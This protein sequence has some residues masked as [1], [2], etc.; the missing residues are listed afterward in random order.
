MLNGNIMISVSMIVKNEEE[1]LE[2]CLESVKDL[3]E[4][5]ILDTG[6]TDKTCKIARKYTDRVYENEYKWNDDF[7]EARNLSKSKCTK[8]WI[9]TIDADER[10]EIGGIEKIRKALNANPKNSVDFHIVSSDGKMSHYQPRLYKNAESIYWKGAI[11]NYLNI[12]EGN[13]KDIKI[14]YGHSSSHKADPN[15]ALRIL[16]KV[17]N[18]DPNLMREVFYLGREYSYRSNWVMALH[19]LNRYILNWIWAPELAEAYLLIAKCH[20][21]LQEGNKARDACLQAIKVNA[22]FKEAIRFMAEMSGPK[23]RKR[24]LEF[25]K[26]AKDGDV[27][28]I[29]G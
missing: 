4:I 17:V 9:L 13:R 20:W 27:L 5:V 19:W 18:K 2:G 15:R 26:T 22:D 7:A 29:R 6:S 3:D 11:H 8:D 10:L 23:N 21:Y 28:F 14:I 24:W 25:A 16:Q 1:C 12:A